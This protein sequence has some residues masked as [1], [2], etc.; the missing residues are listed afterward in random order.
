MDSLRLARIFRAVRIRRRWRQ[1]DLARAAGVSVATVRR[2]EHGQGRGLVLETLL[3]VAQPLEIRIELRTTWR[4]AELDRMLNSGHAALHER[5]AALFATLPAWAW[6]PEVSFAI[7]GERGVIDILAFHAPKGMLLVIELKTEL[8]DIQELL[9]VMDRR[10]RLARRVAAER[11][12][13]VRH[14]SCWIIFADSPTNRRRVA[15]H[16]GVLRHAFPADGRRVRA[17]LRDP[18]EV[19]NA[20]SFLSNHH[21]VSGKAGGSLPKRVRIARGDANRPQP[22]VI[23]PHTAHGSDI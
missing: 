8:V 12:W 23:F 2:I 15:A 20:L 9:G 19:I 18:A 10:R 17:W 14:V 22:S 1:Y 21:S 3:R 13:A 6:A 16:A 5:M 7:Y 4:G 11:G